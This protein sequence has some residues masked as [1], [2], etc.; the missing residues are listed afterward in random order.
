MV[1]EGMFFCPGSQSLYPKEWAQCFF[2]YR[3]PFEY[4]QSAKF[5]TF[6]NFINRLNNQISYLGEIGVGGRNNRFK[7]TESP[8][9]T[10]NSS[11]E[12]FCK[13]VRT[14]GLNDVIIRGEFIAVNFVINVSS[15]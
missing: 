11:V 15:I 4:R 5:S 10:T 3:M 14:N 6:V 9:I 2:G 13:F 12:T 7:T 8:Q 1:A